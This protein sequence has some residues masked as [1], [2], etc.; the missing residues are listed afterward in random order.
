MAEAKKTKTQTKATRTVEKPA[1]VSESRAVATASAANVDDSGDFAVAIA[2]VAADHRLDD[3]AVLD[4]R[5]LT[6]VADY[7]VLG[8]G[9]SDRQMHAVLDRIGDFARSRGRKPYRV[10]DSSSASWILADYVDVVVH[11]FD[12][13]HRSYYDLDSLWGD[14]PRVEWRNGPNAG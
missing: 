13:E 1:A 7:F 14:A 12:A 4:L 9:T 11:L 10:G 8:T 2:R 5:G 6:S 3:V